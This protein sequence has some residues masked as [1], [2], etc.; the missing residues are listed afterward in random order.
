MSIKNLILAFFIV[1]MSARVL[2]AD[3]IPNIGKYVGMWEP[4]SCEGADLSPQRVDLIES[5]K[6]LLFTYVKPK[7][8]EVKNL[9][10]K[11]ET[12]VKKHHHP[13]AWP[14]LRQVTERQVINGKIVIAA[15]Y[16]P[17]DKRH[18]GTSISTALTQISLNESGQMIYE[19]NGIGQQKDDGFYTYELKCIYKK[20]K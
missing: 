7:K 5:G 12:L 8:G 1:G 6:E 13:N 16:Y 9:S 18:K 14:E 10:T 19:R 3:P 4:V 2:A 20:S 17:M 11:P 15:I